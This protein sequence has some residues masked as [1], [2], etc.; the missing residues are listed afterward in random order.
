[1]SHEQPENG[2]NEIDEQGR[3]PTQRRIDEGGASD[4]PADAEWRADDE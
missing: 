2:E 1:M 3:N 4:E